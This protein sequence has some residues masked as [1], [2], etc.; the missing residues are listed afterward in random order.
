MGCVVL[1]K[2][3]LRGR[4]VQTVVKAAER[5]DVAWTATMAVN[6]VVIWGVNVMW[7]VEPRQAPAN[8]VEI[9]AFA[10]ADIALPREPVLFPMEP[11]AAPTQAVWTYLCNRDVL[12]REA[13]DRHC[14]TVRFKDGDLLTMGPLKRDERDAVY[15]RQHAN[16]NYDSETPAEGQDQ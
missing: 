13:A 2:D 11:Q 3:F 16:D 8:D 15:G 9:A 1:L 6:T 14:P 10:P 4:A 5:I 7:Y 12:V